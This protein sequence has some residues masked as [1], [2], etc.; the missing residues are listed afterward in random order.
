MGPD[1]PVTTNQIY[2]VYILASKKNGTL[3]IGVTSNLVKRTWQHKNELTDG[4]TKKYG[5]K[6]LVCYEQYND[7]QKAI[8]REKR[9]KKYNRKW[10]LDLIE[11]HNPHWEDLYYR[12]IDSGFPGLTG[13]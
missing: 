5:V 7:P 8:K 11:R 2:H 12:L 6:N 3:Y 9:L 10:K 13:E 4:F 1:D